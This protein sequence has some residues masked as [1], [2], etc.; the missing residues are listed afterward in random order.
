MNI[1]N[2][3]RFPNILDL[4]SMERESLTRYNIANN[5]R[6]IPSV[7]YPSRSFDICPAMANRRSVSSQVFH[8][9]YG[10]NTFSIVGIPSFFYKN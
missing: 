6:M 10:A 9:N 1:C 3:V 5:R 4:F 7:I 2:T 8:T